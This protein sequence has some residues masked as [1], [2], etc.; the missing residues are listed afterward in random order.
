MP[1][2]WKL[3]V[4]LFVYAFHGTAAGIVHVLEGG[5]PLEGD[6]GGAGYA[7]LAGHA[8]GG[9]VAGEVFGKDGTIVILFFVLCF[10]SGKIGAKAALFLI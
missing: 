3:S 10:L 2:K 9:A 1:E 5:I 7:G 6:G 8:A 4:C